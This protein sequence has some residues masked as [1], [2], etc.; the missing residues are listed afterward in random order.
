MT[1]YVYPLLLA[2]TA[3]AATCSGGCTRTAGYWSTHYDGA[4]P[5]RN[6]TWPAPALTTTAVCNGTWLSVLQSPTQG[7]AWAIVARQDIAAR[8]NLYGGTCADAT[9]LG[10]LATTGDFLAYDCGT[11]PAMAGEALAA[12]DILDAYNNG[13]TGPGHCDDAPTPAPTA[14][15]TPAPTT[16]PPRDCTRTRRCVVETVCKEAVAPSVAICS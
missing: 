11:E 4:R 8:L 5:P 15:A 7:L 12:K 14:A 9:V 3:S 6:A 16:L 1:F 10:A 2:M 13:L